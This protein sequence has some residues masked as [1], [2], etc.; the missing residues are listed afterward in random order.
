MNN[1][2]QFEYLQNSNGLTFKMED[3]YDEHHRKIVAEEDEVKESF[4]R[5]IKNI[6]KN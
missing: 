6:Y 4:Q 3:K 1:T 5:E 2:I